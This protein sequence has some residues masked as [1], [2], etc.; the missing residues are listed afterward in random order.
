MQKCLFIESLR[1]TTH[2]ASFSIILLM[3]TAIV[4]KPLVPIFP[5]K[6]LRLKEAEN[7]AKTR[8]SPNSS[9]LHWALLSGR[10]P[11]GA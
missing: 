2:F 3:I 5:T 9:L 10:P 6:S 7:S 11:G 8:W 4:S 1:G